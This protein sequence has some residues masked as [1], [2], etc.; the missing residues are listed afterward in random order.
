MHAVLKGINK[1]T[2]RLKTGRKV[3]YYYYR[4]TGKSLKG[5]PGTDEFINSYNEALREFKGSRANDQFASVL[6]A[7]SQSY[8]FQNQ[9]APTT[10]TEYRRK[11]A[12]LDREF[13]DLPIAALKKPEV[14][15]IFIE[16]GD[17]VAAESGPR[18]ADY[19]LSVLSAC[20]S[21]AVQRAILPQ[22][23]IKGFAR[24]HSADRSDIIWMADHIEKF[25]RVASEE[26]QQALMIG[27]HSGLRQGDVISL[28]W[29]NFD[30]SDLCVSINKNIRKGK[31]SRPVII[32]C[33]TA[34]KG[35]LNQ[36][37]RRSEYILCTTTGVKFTS[38]HFGKQ[39]Q[40]AYRKAGLGNVDLH[41]HD[42]RGTAVVLLAEAG[43]TIPQIAAITKH[44]LQTV[45]AI[46]EKYLTRTRHLASTAICLFEASPTAGFA[47]RLQTGPQ[48]TQI[49]EPKDK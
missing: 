9:L 29:D 12:H 49:S 6:T 8:Q 25:M 48:K 31:A 14:R 32:P 11:I 36:M 16:Y 23:H 2:K 45:T 42:L 33:T 46:L 4:A 44:S 38:R 30:G 40:A 20:L 47:N 43:C 17:I 7:Y 1:V 24:Y 27:L 41:F 34:L 39:W 18:E 28:R 5:I 10:K 22:N 35:M 15:R 19:R 21:W 13:G 3:I 37:P 26:M